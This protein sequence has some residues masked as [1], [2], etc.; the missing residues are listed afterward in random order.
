MRPLRSSGAGDAQGLSS[1]TDG[2][3][4]LDP[5]PADVP[6][7]V[8]RH[9]HRQRRVQGRRHPG[10]PRVGARRCTQGGQGGV[11]QEP[12][13]HEVHR[14]GG[15]PPQGRARATPTPSSRR[16]AT[17]SSC[18]SRRPT[19]SRPPRC[20]ASSRPIVQSANISVTGQPPKFDV[21]SEQVEDESLS[22]IQYY[23]PGL[24]GWAIAIGCDVRRRGQPR[25][26]AQERSAAPAA[27][28]TRSVRRRW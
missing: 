20:R 8:R 3:V 5:V 1:A 16:P 11:R 9:L 14:R 4:L 7:A 6:R 23:T 24:L 12:R 25:G 28:R 2:V 22:A 15:G 13:H 21:K 18:T 10:R 27:A 19:R 26:V 17:P